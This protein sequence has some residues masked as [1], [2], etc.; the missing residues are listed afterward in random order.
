VGHVEDVVIWYD[1]TGL[2]CL[3]LDVGFSLTATLLL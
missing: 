2:F 1:W 3:L